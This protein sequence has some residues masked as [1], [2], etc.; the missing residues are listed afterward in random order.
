MKKLITTCL[1]LSAFSAA[2]FAQSKAGAPKAKNNIPASATTTSR[3]TGVEK[4]A[5]NNARAIQKQ[6]GLTEEQYKGIYSAELDYQRQ[7]Q[8]A[9]EAGGAGPGQTMQMNMGRDQRFQAVMS[10]D[11]FSKY[12]AA[13]GSA[14]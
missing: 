7:A 8:M 2:T 14:K 4:L 12:Q 9:A 6:Y 5:E 11:Q 10:A 1:M 13:K 3:V